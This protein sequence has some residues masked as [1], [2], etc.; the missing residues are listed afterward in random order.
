MM[1]GELLTICQGFP[2]SFLFIDIFCI[3]DIIPVVWEIGIARIPV[4]QRTALRCRDRRAVFYLSFKPCDQL[5]SN[6]DHKLSDFGLC[7]F[8]PKCFLESIPCGCELFNFA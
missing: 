2:G 4:E 3:Y 1:N 7:E 5:I 6:Q 8:I